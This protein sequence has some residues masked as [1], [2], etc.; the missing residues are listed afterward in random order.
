MH[1]NE[2]GFRIDFK[3]WGNALRL[4][5]TRTLFSAAAMA[6]AIGLAG[7]GGAPPKTAGEQAPPAMPVNV[8]VVSMKPVPVSDSYVATIKS[9]RSATIQPQVSG[10]ITQIFVHSGQQVTAGERLM[11]INPQQQQ[12]VVAQAKATEQQALAVY[13]YNQKDIV[14][15]RSLFSSGITSKQAFQQASQTYDSSKAT[16]ESDVAARESAQQQLAYYHIS[17]PFAGVVG[18]V[19]VH[20]GDYVSPTTTLTTVDDNTELEAY[21]YIPADR[22][23]QVRV[24]LPVEI[25]DGAGHVLDRT[26]IYFVSP[27]VDNGLQAI[28][29]KAKIHTRPEVLRNLQLVRAVVIWSTADAPTVPILAVSQ[30]GNQ[31]FVYVAKDENGHYA[32]LQT[33]VA[34]GDTV[35]NDY[36]VKSGLQ[37]GDKVIVSG[38]QL[39]VNGAPVQPI[40]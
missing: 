39:L 24:G 10:N 23:S 13:Q 33:S 26:K 25:T 7:C 37:V 31:H 36:E 6:V 35:G 27:Q 14:R 34:L 30:I 40:S 22:A 18:D 8:D 9:R 11:E 38:M 29:A 20:I 28:L 15:Q 32:A 21:I 3:N 19:P 1:K 17:A 12:A 16:Y 2:L 4:S 5:R